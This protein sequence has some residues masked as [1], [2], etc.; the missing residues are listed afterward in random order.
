[1]NM[2][3]FHR[4]FFAFFLLIGAIVVQFNDMNGQQFGK[5]KVQY[6]DFSWK[7]IKTKHFD[8][9]FHEEGEYLARYA[10]IHAERALNSIQD[11][12]KYSIN[13]RISLI[14]YNSHNDF[15]QTN[16]VWDFMPEGV[17]GVTELFKNRITLP[18]EGHYDQFNHVIHHELVHAVINDMFFGGSVQSMMANNIRTEL[19]LWMNEGFAEYESAGGYDTKTDMFMRDIALSEFIKGFD[20]LEGY[21]AYR[22]GQAFYWYVSEKYGERKIGELLNRLRISGTLDL[23]FKGSFGKSVEDFS[24]EWVREMKKKYLPDLDR[25]EQLDDMAIRITNHKKDHSF[26]NSSPALSPTGDTIAFI[27]NRDGQFGVFL[28]SLSNRDKEPEELINSGRAVDFEELNILTPGISWSPDGKKLA[29]SAKSG[30]EDAL[31]IVDVKTGDYVKH[32]FSIKTLTSAIWSPDGATI[33]FIGTVAEQT[34]IWLFDVRSGSIIRA[35]D[36]VFSDSHPVWSPDSRTIYFVSDRGD[37]VQGPYKAEDIAMWKHDPHISDVYQVELETGLMGRLTFDPNSQKTSLAVTNNGASLIFVSDNNGI[38]NVY[39]LQLEASKV[40]PRT[41]SLN[42]ITQLSMS[43]DGSSLV[44]TS[45]NNGGYDLFQMRYPLERRAYDSLPLTKF[46]MSKKDGGSTTEKP[47]TVQYSIPQQLQ[48]YGSGVEVE[49]SR[50]QLIQPNQDIARFPEQEINSPITSIARAQM[51]N[52]IADPLKTPAQDYKITFSN[53]VILANAGVSTFWGYQG[54]AQMLFSDMLGDHQIYVQANLFFDI[55]NSN[56]LFSYSYLPQ[57]IDWNITAN[58][59][60]GYGLVKSDNAPA[61]YY[62]R[63]RN[64]GVGGLASLPTSRFRRFELGMQYMHLSKEN[65]EFPQEPVT[66]RDMIVSQTNMVYDNTMP[67]WYGPSKG[68]R[69]SMSVKAAPRLQDDGLGLAVMNLDFRQ[70]YTLTDNFLF[71]AVRGAGGLGISTNPDQNFY[72]LGG[73]DNWINRSFA[74]G[75]LPF[76]SPEDFAFLQYALPLRGWDVNERF[77]RKYAMMNAE[78]RFPLFTALLAGPVPVVFQAFQAAFF[79]DMGTAWSDQVSWKLAQSGDYA[80]FRY[81]DSGDLLMSAGVGIRTFLF[82]LPFRVDVAWR[83]EHLGWSMPQWLFSL[84][85]DF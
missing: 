9:Y 5:N 46:K 44:F 1:M 33:A 47:E 81:P 7:F 53:D 39:E 83:N 73:I 75:T 67:G 69:Y 77:G 85:G 36:D 21:Y 41:N 80:H 76:N 40:I 17:G 61:Y 2:K 32:E 14:I 20:N 72:F 26:Y 45:Q 64:Y 19:P 71:L 54:I 59:N 12:L 6:Q 60:V 8:V 15:Q 31:Y 84:G 10:G 4:Y 57:I 58:H 24:E 49:F 30:G 65:M 25:F 29:I 78:L 56:F 63:F 74:G 13:K 79:M 52:E 16:V 35:T 34:D 42:G 18:F 37:F 23:A 38:G 28:L 51:E 62:Y 50:Q 66:S 22:G 68:T 11:Q 70:Y 55:R 48:G 27:S 43:M 3:S 82:G